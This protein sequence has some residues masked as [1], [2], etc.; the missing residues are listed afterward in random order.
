MHRKK[1]AKSAT[2]SGLNLIGCGLLLGLLPT[3]SIPAGAADTKAAL[4]ALGLTVVAVDGVKSRSATVGVLESGAV[5]S[6]THSTI[7]HD[8]TLRNDSKAPI[9][10]G[11]LQPTC[12]CTSVLLGEAK[13]TTKTLAPGEQVK[14]HASVN[15]GNFHGSIYKAI[16][17]MAEDNKTV[18]ATMEISA[19]IKDPISFSMNQIRFDNV[20]AGTSRSMP[21]TVTV[22]P[23]L[24]AMGT[25]PQLVSS[26]P[27][28]QVALVA[29]E[30][31]EDG[32][33]KGA[34]TNPPVGAAAE[35][36]YTVTVAP[37][38]PGGLL[39]GTISF[40]PLAAKSTPPAASATTP[41][42]PGAIT[43]S[44][45]AL[46]A[47][48]Q[49]TTLDV[50]GEVVGN[51]KA[52][53]SMVVFGT[54]KDSKQQVTL[55][56]TTPQALGNLQ[57]ASSNPWVLVRLTPASPATGAADKQTASL[58]LSIKPDAPVGGLQAQ[59]LITNAAGER[60]R[61]PVSAYIAP[62]PAPATP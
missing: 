40:S 61:L 3:L 58:E 9:V 30:K 62:A 31:V 51:I 36:R 57:V 35:Q 8:F 37:Q 24:A 52:A 13:E 27:D 59:V 42:Q 28:I 60:L 38:T 46:S 10:I 34:E 55:T 41:A 22:D 48:L 39:S 26:N 15:I 11:R 54:A 29:S 44:P 43:L 19:I 21:L 45:E 14:V 56:G 20:V 18:L 32:K 12:G 49:K 7:E 4:S 6:L 47:I 53:P 5:D 2:Q 17:A 16:R 33:N 1:F 50:A 23:R 25:L